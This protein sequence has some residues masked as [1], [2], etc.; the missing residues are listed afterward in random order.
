MQNETEYFKRTYP[1][2]Y[3]L[4]LV[5]T[6]QLVTK[7]STILGKNIHSSLP[8]ITKELREKIEEF[9]SE[10]SGLGSPL[11]ENDADKIQSVLAMVI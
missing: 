3:D 7:L 2:L 6:S 10:L 8:D 4:G 9:N 11:P 1:D 5:G